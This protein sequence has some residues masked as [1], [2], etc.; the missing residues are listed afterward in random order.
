MAAPTIMMPVMAGTRFGLSA[1][2]LAKKYGLDEDTSEGIVKE[3]GATEPARMKTAT[4]KGRGN[5]LGYQTGGRPTVEETVFGNQPLSHEMPKAP[6]AKET[7]PELKK[8]TGT[9]GGVPITDMGEM[10][11][12][13]KDYNIAVEAGYDPESIESWVKENRDKLFN[14][15]PEAQKTLGITDYTQ[16]TPGYFDYSARGG[17]GFGMEDVNY[18][19]SQGAREEDIRKL[20]QQAPYVGEQAYKLYGGSML[21]TPENVAKVQAP[22]NYPTYQASKPTTVSA[23]SF[24]YGSYGQAGFGGE[25][26]SVAKAR[27]YSDEQIASLAASAPGGL[28]GPKVREYLSARGY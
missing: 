6:E 25:D 23:P 14:I 19:R 2:E 17:A 22:A 27:G 16:T 18:L 8:F 20:A 5:V 21:A 10:G 12:G 24:D 11:F 28:V 4:Y 7:A 13:M 1:K 3:F 26:L 15:G 9:V